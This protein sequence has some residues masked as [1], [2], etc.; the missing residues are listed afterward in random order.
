[1]ELE[2]GFPSNATLEDNTAVIP[3][4]IRYRL[5]VLLYD[6]TQVSRGLDLYGTYEMQSR[7]QV[8]IIM[9]AT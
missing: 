3:N 2:Q 1:M 8:C 9:M 4:A 5:Y 7:M 6:G